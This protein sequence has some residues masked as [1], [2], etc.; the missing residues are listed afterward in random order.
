MIVDVENVIG[1]RTGVGGGGGV[2]HGGTADGALA[3][4]TS[5]ESE[6]SQE[7]AAEFGG[8]EVVQDRVDG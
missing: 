6:Q 7:S 1:S 4:E 2:R 5:A 8:H 3:G